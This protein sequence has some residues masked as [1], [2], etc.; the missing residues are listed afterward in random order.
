MSIVWHQERQT[1]VVLARQKNRLPIKSQN[2]RGDRRRTFGIQS[3]RILVVLYDP[4]A[5]RNSMMGLMF[6]CRRRT[7]CTDDI[8]NQ[9]PPGH[10][11]RYGQYG[12]DSVK[13][14]CQYL[15]PRGQDLLVLFRPSQINI[16]LAKDTYRRGF[17]GAAPVDVDL[18]GRI[19]IRSHTPNYG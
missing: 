19:A 13:S 12:S 3:H 4:E 9:A 18:A 17:P 8:G 7:T 1:G 14:S 15:W 11:S 2:R 10:K 6:T 16:H 5:L